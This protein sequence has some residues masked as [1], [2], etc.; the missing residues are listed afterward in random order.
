V[1]RQRWRHFLTQAAGTRDGTLSLTLLTVD[2]RDS[3]NNATTSSFADIKMSPSAMRRGTFS[4][5]AGCV[6]ALG[7]RGLMMM[8]EEEMGETSD[9]VR[10]W[11]KVDF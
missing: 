11:E 3:S 6:T 9:D 1:E 7:Y 8:M 4:G 2:N 10:R 5:R